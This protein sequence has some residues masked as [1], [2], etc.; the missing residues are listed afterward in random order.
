MS[1]FKELLDKLPHL[2]EAREK[3]EW[4]DPASGIIITELVPNSI[5]Q[6]A[7]F[8]STLMLQTSQGGVPLTF[9]INA[10]NLE[11]AVKGWNAAARQAVTE[12][13]AQMQKNARRIVMPTPAM[14]PGRP[15]A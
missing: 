9:S 11:E 3:R 2:E 6:P 15:H 5:L 7:L 8:T 4:A 13:D 10:P 1:G 12:F 14:L